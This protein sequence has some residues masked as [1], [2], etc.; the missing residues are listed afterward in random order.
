MSYMIGVDVGGT[1]TDLSLFNTENDTIFNYKLSSTPGDPSQAIVNGIT[2]TLELLDISPEEISYL[3]HGTTVATNALIEKKGSRIGIITTQ[4]MKDLMEIGWQKRPNLYD[5]LRPKAQSIIPP[6]L[7]CEVPERILYDGTIK[8]PLDEEETIRVIQYLKKQ[9]VE[10]IAV[11]TLFSYLNPVHENRIK[12]LIHEYFPEAYVSVSHE[13]VHEFREYSR[14]STTALNAYLGP[15]MKKYVQHFE[16]SVKN[17][18]VK[19]NPYVTQSNGSIISI[20][21][22]IDCPIKTAVSGPSAGVIGAAYMGGLCG[23]KN[24]ITFDMGGTSIDVSLIENGKPQL[25]NERLVEGYP[26]R[27]PMIDIITLGAGGGSIAKI[28]EGGA[29]KVGPQSAGA[30]PG[31]AC[32][33]RGGINPCVTDANIVLGK[34]NQKKILGGRM[35]VDVELAKKAIQTEICDKSSLT[36]AEAASGIISVVNSNMM[37][38]IRIV[39]VER[40]YDARD[41]ALMAFGGAGPLHACEV[42]EELGI[43]EVLIPPNPGTLCSLG[44]LMADTKFDLSRSRIMLAKA[45]NL[46]A[47]NEVFQEMLNEGNNLLDKE[48]IPAAQRSFAASVDARY[49]RQNYELNIPLSGYEVTEDILKEALHLFHEAHEKSFGYCNENFN[50]QLVN[51]RLSAIGEIEKPDLICEDLKENAELPAPQEVRQVLFVSQKEYLPT[52]VY[53]RD[54]FVPGVK[55]SGP[56]IIEQMD[57]TTV[58]PPNWDIFTDGY[59]NIHAS[60]RGGESN[61]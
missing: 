20:S 24:I 61:E 45:E 9:K 22:T 30:T 42:A 14:M 19:V 11:C 15:V 46:G 23:I 29:L 16:D 7:K 10:A 27:I 21:E 40:G 36:L 49:E 35:D 59:M 51:F 6:G 60:Y 43:E 52:P 58:I 37:R 31:P 32:Y 54:G 28:D 13:L 8:I 3:A 34:L 2:E 25:S 50:V 56:M 5:L 41:F 18:G 39:S 38:A 17:V 44:L 53:Q 57:C 1:F 47:M 33:M 4:G 48:K 26:A 55:S 12:E